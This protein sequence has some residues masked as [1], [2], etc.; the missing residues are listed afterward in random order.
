[1]LVDDYSFPDPTFDYNTFTSWL[2]NKG[3]KPG[4]VFRESQLITLCDE[5]L[6]RLKDNRLH[7]QLNNYIKAKKYPCSLFIAAWYLLRLGY[8]KHL[9]FDENL[10]AS[11]IINILPKSFKPFEDKALEIIAATEFA[12]A[13]KRIEYSFIEGRLIA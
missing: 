2:T 11:R 7:E 9:S 3:F 5:V 12:G 1:M 8:L 10:Y 6:H 13:E 4:I